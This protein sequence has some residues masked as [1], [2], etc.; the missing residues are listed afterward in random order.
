MLPGRNKQEVKFCDCTSD[1]V[2]LVEMGYIG[3]TPVYPSTAFSIRLLKHFH[4]YWKHCTLRLQ[5]FTRA[6]DELLNDGNP[7]METRS[8]RVSLLHHSC[9]N[10]DESKVSAQPR[11]WRVPF[12]SSLDA[13]RTILCSIR[14]LEFRLLKFKD[15]D[16]LAAN[17]PRCFGPPVGATNTEEPD[18]IV[19][20][21]GNFQH[22]RHAAASVP[23]PGYQPIMPELFIPSEE[24]ADATHDAPSNAANEEVVSFFFFKLFLSLM[25]P[26]PTL[27]SASL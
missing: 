25:F 26:N 18:H 5:G 16:H 27:N 22:R 12:S 10:N 9:L 11:D 13:Y 6:L 19:C 2:R 24:I 3:A 15:I 21:D 14:D 17:C 23:I 1:P 8:G 20:L 7:P 4:V